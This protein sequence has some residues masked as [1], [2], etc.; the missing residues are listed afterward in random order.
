[1]QAKEL[2]ATVL[3]MRQM[4]LG[5]TLMKFKRI[6][7]EIMTLGGEKGEQVQ[8]SNSLN[9]LQGIFTPPTIGC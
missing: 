4:A 2:K 5:L 8:Q 6:N 1:M 7:A 3:G 9:N